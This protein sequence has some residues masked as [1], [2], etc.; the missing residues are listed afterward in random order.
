VIGSW[1][2]PEALGIAA[3]IPLVIGAVI[4]V[5]GVLLAPRYG[6][7]TARAFAHFLSLGLEFLLAAGLIRLLGYYTFEMIGIAAAIILARRI[8]LLGLGY[9]VRATE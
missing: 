3:V 4:I 6:L 9:G 8:V 5:I 7:H 1:L 2:P